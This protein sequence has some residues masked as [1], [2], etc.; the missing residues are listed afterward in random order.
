VKKLAQDVCS[1]ERLRRANREL[2]EA[3]AALRECVVSDNEAEAPEES[4]YHIEG[5]VR[6]A[7][8]DADA[9]L[10]NY[11]CDDLS[12]DAALRRHGWVPYPHR[13]SYGRF[14]EDLPTILKLI[15]SALYEAMQVNDRCY[16]RRTK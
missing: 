15:G 13:L 16:I 5:F 9:A 6:E 10:A 3:L 8:A 12:Q 7:V 11:N 4:V 14:Q 1:V 2:Y